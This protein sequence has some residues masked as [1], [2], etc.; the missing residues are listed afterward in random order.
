M[1]SFLIPKRGAKYNNHL[2][3]LPTILAYSSLFAIFAVADGDDCPSGQQQFTFDNGRIQCVNT[4]SCTG[5][6]IWVDVGLHDPSCVQIACS[7]T[8]YIDVNTDHTPSC[9]STCPTL[10]SPTTLQSGVR[11]CVDSCP[12][13]QFRFMYRN[14]TYTCKQSCTGLEQALELSN[15]TI[16]CV[17]NN[18][19]DTT[20]VLKLDSQ[21]TTGYQ[22]SASNGCPSGQ[23]PYLKDNGNQV[24]TEQCSSDHF[25]IDIY[26]MQPMCFP[27]PGCASDKYININ[28]NKQTECVDDCGVN[29]ARR[30]DNGTIMCVGSCPV[31]KTQMQLDDS[32]YKC[33]DSCSKEEINKYDP[34]TNTFSCVV[35]AQ[36]ETSAFERFEMDSGDLICIKKCSDSLIHVDVGTDIPICRAKCSGQQPYLNVNLITKVQSCVAICPDGKIH[37]DYGDQIIKCVEN[38]PPSKFQFRKDD[39][40]SVCIKPCLQ[41]QIPI[42]M[43]NGNLFPTCKSNN[44]TSS[45][46]PYIDLTSTSSWSCISQQTCIARQEGNR[47]PIHIEQFEQWSYD[48]C[49]DQDLSLAYDQG[50]SY[51]YMDG[52]SSSPN[53][54]CSFDHPCK[55]FEDNNYAFSKMN[56]TVGH[57]IFLRNSFVLNVTARINTTSS[58]Q[59]LFISYPIGGEIQQ[60]INATKTGMFYLTRGWAVFKSIMFRVNDN[61]PSQNYLIILEFENSKLDLVNCAFGGIYSNEIDRG[62]L[63]CMTKATLN[64]EAL[65]VNQIKMLQYPVIS[66]DNTAGLIN[67]NNSRFQGVNRTRGSG[68]AI[69]CNLVSQSGG[70][71]IGANTTFTNCVSKYSFEW[72]SQSMQYDI[73]AIYVKIPEG[74]YHRFDLRGA[75]YMTSSVT[76]IGKGLFIETGNLTEAMRRSDL[77]TK[78]GTITPSVANQEMYMMGIDETQRWLTTPL[79]YTVQNVTNGIY[80]INNP[81]TGYYWYNDASGK[82]SGN[83]NEFCGFVRFPCA[84]FGKAVS[85][86]IAQHPEQNAEVKIGII[87]GYNLSSTTQ[88]EAQGRKVSISNQLKYSDETPSTEPIFMFVKGNG[89]FSFSNGSLSVVLSIFYVGNEPCTSQYIILMNYNSQS[90]DVKQ[91]TFAVEVN[92]ITIPHGFVEVRG[93]TVSIDQMTVKNMKM[94]GCSVIKLNNG[95]RQVNISRITF[96]NIQ[97]TASNGGCAIFGELNDSS[98]IKLSE[99][100]FTQCVSLETVNQTNGGAVQLQ[101]HGAILDMDKVVFTSCSGLNGG[102]MFIR[103]DQSSI[104]RMAN[105]SK[106]LTC[107]DNSQSGGGAYFDVNEYSSCEID[108]VE[109]TTCKAQ[110]FGGGIYG[111]ISGGGILTIRNTTTFTTCSCVGT[112]RYQEGGAINIVIKD[113][114]SKFQVLS[115]TSFTS[116]SCKDLGGAININGSLGALIDIRQVTFTSCSSQGGGGLNAVLESG[117]IMNITNEVTFSLCSS[118]SLSNGGGIRAKITEP[119]TCLLISTNVKFDQCK[120]KGQGGGIYVQAVQTKIIDINGVTFD[121]CEATQG[122]GAIST[123]LTDG[124]TFYIEG[125]TNFTTCKTTGAAADDVDLGGGAVCAYV[126]GASSHFRVLDNAKF[127]KCESTFKGGAIFIQA[128]MSQLLEINSAIFQDCISNNEGGGIYSYITN[129]GS[130]ILSNASKF[131]KCKSTSV[132]VALHVLN[133]FEFKIVNCD[134]LLIYVHI[135]PPFGLSQFWINVSIN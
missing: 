29:I 135:P 34:D 18:C 49:I 116:C 75:I 81:N 31:G 27:N 112:N 84:T 101:L 129:G 130:F 64:I 120:T 43:R 59:R 74:A 109:F 63:T 33:I 3:I 96:N 115:S 89:Q 17:V 13:G 24:C 15:G 71:T 20:P 53:K 104:M 55:I 68:A 4:A 65:T 39:S 80:H 121:K 122:G 118:T 47:Y 117:T 107:N 12:D 99:L 5:D 51:Y 119:G 16:S 79:Q 60:Y 76:W 95:T 56:E 103:L 11:K 42:D 50:S 69:Q 8:E 127:D 126:Q 72:E 67:I 46:S 114:N 62:L 97:S 21:S 106:F 123:V 100:N 128:E 92:D 7:S 98:G 73:G 77:G 36:C 41:N 133:Q 111:T 124:G 105:L 30:F 113:G 131:T 108:N 94:N 2:N 125:S 134:P 35:S 61:F 45:T 85:R 22:C 87:Y 93:G 28:S 52:F 40:S 57:L 26:Q 1:T 58:Q 91:C 19:Q 70:L 9:V 44:C 23:F 32:T 54:N 6:K 88:I 83:D 110:Q 48:K 25:L 132:P 82:T 37:A 10:K 38:C 102:G 66:L 14:G 90:L 86:S 78:Y